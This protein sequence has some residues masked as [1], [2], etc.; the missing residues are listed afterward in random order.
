MGAN[1]FKVKTENDCFIVICPRC[2]LNLK[3]GDFTL[4]FCGVRH[5][6]VHGNSCCTCSKS[7]SP[8][9][10]NH[11]LAVWHCRFRSRRLCLRT[12]PTIVIAHMFCA[13]RDIEQ[14]WHSRLVRGLGARGPEFDSRI[15]HPCFN[16]F[17]FRVAK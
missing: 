11:I 12:V 14:G 15:S 4:L 8:F 1:G 2:R 7:I 16:F 10:P 13:S 9:L 6:E 5:T 17:P 3:L